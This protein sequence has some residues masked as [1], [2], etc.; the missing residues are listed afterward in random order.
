MA[1]GRRC[2]REG[3]SGSDGETVA[4]VSVVCF[5][6]SQDASRLRDCVLRCGVPCAPIACVSCAS[7]IRD[8]GLCVCVLSVWEGVREA[9]SCQLL[10]LMTSVD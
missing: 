1:R 8:V 10:L 9:T 2:A 6:G 7:T 5:V 3:A 4:R